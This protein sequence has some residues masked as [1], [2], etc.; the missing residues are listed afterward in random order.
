LEEDH[1]S[2]KLIIK[3]LEERMDKDST[4]EFFKSVRVTGLIPSFCSEHHKG[5]S[6]VL[7]ELSEGIT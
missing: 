4:D 3:N 2:I 6:S 1:V 7:M 5:W